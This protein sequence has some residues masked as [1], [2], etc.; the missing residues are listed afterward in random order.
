LALKDELP[1]GE[2]ILQIIVKDTLAK[3]KT[4]LATQWVQ[5]EIIE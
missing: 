3:E 1:P 2:Y 5:F 4:N